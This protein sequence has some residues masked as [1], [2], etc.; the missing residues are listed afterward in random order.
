MYKMLLDQ[1]FN[2]TIKKIMK[3]FYK[4]IAVVTIVAATGF[5]VY[6]TQENKLHLSSLAME[7]VEALDRGESYISSGICYGA[8]PHF[9]D[10]HCP[11]GY[12]ICCWAHMDVFGEN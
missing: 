3:K 1:F 6:C 7:N 9:T 2:F 10:V 4:Y 8:G 11:G 5:T 12:I